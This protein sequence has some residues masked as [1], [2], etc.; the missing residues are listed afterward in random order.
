[1]LQEGILVL[2]EILHE[3]SARRP[4]PQSWL[5]NLFH[6]EVPFSIVSADRN[7]TTVRF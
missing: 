1:M 5:H 3:R 7:A 6:S 2:A 4:M